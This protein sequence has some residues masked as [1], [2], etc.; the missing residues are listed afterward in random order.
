MVAASVWSAGRSAQE[1][2]GP[3]VVAMFRYAMITIASLVAASA[4]AQQ[5]GE[6][7]APAP[8]TPAASN[9]I[10]PMAEPLPGD[11][12]TY[13]VRDEIT[14]KISATREIVVTEVTPADI[15]V[16]WRISG[17]NNTEGLDVYDRSWNLKSSG[18]WKYLP[19]DG[20][21]IRSP[22]QIGARWNFQA[23]DINAGSGRILKRT[24]DSKVVGQE[25]ITT[26]AGTFDTFKIETFISRRLTNDR[27]RKEEFTGQTWYAPAIDHWV[28]R[29]IVS[30]ADNHLRSNNTIELVAYGRK[31]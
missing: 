15:S 30:R 26:K 3:A 27:T 14:G 5:Q 2:E 4:L 25:T 22:L 18:P 21:G 17:T 1:R 28:K 10:V 24:G 20:S 12:W 6:P 19:N 7:P 13:E 16:R 8:T 31:Q 23:D 11:H 29:A 9:A